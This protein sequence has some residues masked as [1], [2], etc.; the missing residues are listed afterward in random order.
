MLPQQSPYI[1]QI[2]SN[3]EGSIM[4]LTQC[5][6]GLTHRGLT[7]CLVGLT[8]CG[9]HTVP[10]GSDSPWASHSGPHT[11]GL[12]QCLVGLTHHGPHTVPGGSDSLWASHSARW[13]V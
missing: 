2:N 5:L 8:H 3:Q 9:P 12:T 11:V 7:Q 4:G 6:V 10:G 13:W 1:Y